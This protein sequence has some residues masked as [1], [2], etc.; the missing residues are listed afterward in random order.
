MG[1]F[2]EKNLH[3]FCNT[4]FVFDE[5]LIIDYLIEQNKLKYAFA[6]S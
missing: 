4:Q 2:D 1:C 5:T 3:L 6:H